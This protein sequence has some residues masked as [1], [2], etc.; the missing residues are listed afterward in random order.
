MA[1]ISSALRAE[2]EKRAHNGT[3][4]LPAR[5]QRAHPSR[6]IGTIINTFKTTI[7]Y[8]NFIMADNVQQQATTV[9]QETQPRGGLIESAEEAQKHRHVS[10]ISIDSALEGY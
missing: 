7:D 6:G 5:P 3:S 2:V 4:D 10:K 8:L 1:G 9:E